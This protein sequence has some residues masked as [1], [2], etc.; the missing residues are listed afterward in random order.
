MNKTIIGALCLIS[1]TSWA[2]CDS[3]MNFGNLSA[4]S[5]TKSE[6]QLRKTIAAP[7]PKK[8]A[9]AKPPAQPK[10]QEPKTKTVIGQ[11][12]VVKAKIANIYKSPSHNADKFFT[13]SEGMRLVV[14]KESGEWIGVKMGEAAK[15]AL[16]WVDKKNLTFT[17]EIVTE[18]T[19]PAKPR[20]T[21]Q[22]SR[23]SFKTGRADVVA[24]AYFDLARRFAATPYVY[25][26]N[27]PATGMDCSAFVKLVFSEQGINLPRTAREQA[28]VGM[29]VD[30]SK[31]VLRPGD[32]LYFRYKHD[33]IDHAG[34]YCGNGYYVHCNAVRNGV[35][36]DV[37]DT[38]KNRAAFVVAKRDY[39]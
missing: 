28:N 13:A 15:G 11:V 33:Y 18:I 21:A 36:V 17:G 35:S 26:G 27:S 9:Q 10:K 12:G 23:G 31:D 5:V 37:L 6:P 7:Q 25:G 30:A 34:I 39:R 29:T 4:P 3:E 14:V 19:E 20:Q 22:V 2:F 16:G 1:L 24:A 8:Q 38:P 32:R